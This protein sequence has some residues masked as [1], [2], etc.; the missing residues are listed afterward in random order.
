MGVDEVRL[1]T[2]INGK[3]AECT[4]MELY[5]YYIKRDIALCGISFYQFA[6]SCRINGTR[7][8]KESDEM[9]YAEALEYAESYMTVKGVPINSK[10][11]TRCIR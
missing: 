5:E 11:A 4:E 1:M 2:I 10:E 7:I 9:D 6:N 3:I 8:I